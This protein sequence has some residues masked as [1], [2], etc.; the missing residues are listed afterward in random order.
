MCVPSLASLS[1]S[2]IQCCL[3]LWY[4]LQTQLGSGVALALVWAGSL[5]P[6]TL[7][8]PL[9]WELLYAMGTAI[10]KKKKKVIISYSAWTLSIDLNTPPE[11]KIKQKNLWDDQRDLSSD[12]RCMMIL[13]NYC[14]FL[15]VYVQLT[16]VP[17]KCLCTKFWY[18]SMCYLAWW[19]GLYR[20]D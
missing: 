18:L 19:K 3:E 7:I 14:Q 17:Q 5:E 16:Y 6:V 4:R 11:H 9:A 10:K 1:G 8:W 13:K 12:Q 15:S 20:Y 2:R